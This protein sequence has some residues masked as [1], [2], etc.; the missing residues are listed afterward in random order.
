MAKKK[1]KDLGKQIKEM[2]VAKRKEAEASAPAA[3][4]AAKQPEV[5]FDAWFA[6][7]KDAIP[8][9]HQRDV[10]K[11]DFISRKTEMM[12]TMEHFDKALALFG[13]KL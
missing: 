5:S 6:R 10:I 1:T 7:R 8:R 2:E 11:A 4:V 13:V 9:G 12:G 3:P